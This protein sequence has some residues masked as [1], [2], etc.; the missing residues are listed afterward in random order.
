MRLGS[1]S[2]GVD[3]GGSGSPLPSTTRAGDGGCGAPDAGAEGPAAAV[4]AVTFPDLCVP[5]VANSPE[6]GT[7]GAPPARAGAPFPGVTAGGKELPPPTPGNGA[8]SPVSPF[9][10]SAV[11]RSGPVASLADARGG[12]CGGRPDATRWPA[13]DVSARSG[14]GLLEVFGTGWAAGRA[15]PGGGTSTGVGS[16]CEAALAPEGAGS[17][18]LPAGGV[19]SEFTAYAPTST[20]TIA[21]AGVQFWYRP[22]PV[23][24]YAH[25]TGR[26]RPQPRIAP[27]EPPH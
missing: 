23:P 18:P 13:G 5:G 2:D 21:A 16:G 25:C 3:M 19:S 1:M 20:P 4:A 24:A 9:V 17:R 8:F 15:P 11:A 10:R 26:P 12:G 7:V 22:A 6:S 14:P 27:V